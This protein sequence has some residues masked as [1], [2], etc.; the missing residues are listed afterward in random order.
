MAWGISPK[1]SKREKIKAEMND[2][3]MGQNSCGIIDY[4]TYSEMYDFTMELLDKMYAQGIADGRII[5]EAIANDS[6]S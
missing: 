6:V 3:L 1:A 5:D 2:F 4:S